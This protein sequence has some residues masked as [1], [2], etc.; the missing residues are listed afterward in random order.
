MKELER[1][2]IIKLHQRCCGNIYELF[3][4]VRKERANVR[5][6]L[7]YF[8]SV[9][10]IIYL[11]SLNSQAVSEQKTFGEEVLYLSVLAVEQAFDPKGRQTVIF[12]NYS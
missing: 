4:F 9:S 3:Y 7:W 1:N 12:V 5:I 11:N 8:D 10:Q 6:V 2:K